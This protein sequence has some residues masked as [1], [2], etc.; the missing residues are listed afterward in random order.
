MEDLCC[1]PSPVGLPQKGCH[2]V[3]HWLLCILL[4]LR[5]LVAEG[6]LIAEQG[7]LEYIE[8]RQEFNSEALPIEFCEGLKKGIDTFTDTMQQ[9]RKRWPIRCFTKRVK[10]DRKTRI[11]SNVLWWKADGKKKFRVFFQR[12]IGQKFPSRHLVNFLLKLKKD[13]PTAHKTVFSQYVDNHQI[14]FPRTDRSYESFYEEL[15]GL[16][17]YEA[18]MKKEGVPAK[19]WIVSIAKEKEMEKSEFS[20]T[21][22]EG[23]HRFLQE[24]W[25]NMNQNFVVELKGYFNP[26]PTVSLTDVVLNIGANET[27]MKPRLIT[28]PSAQV[29]FSQADCERVEKAV[30]DGEKVNLTATWEKLTIGNRKRDHKGDARRYVSTKSYPTFVIEIRRDARTDSTTE[31]SVKSVKVGNHVDVYKEFH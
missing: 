31:I 28:C 25:Q 7:S 12:Q 24:A 1:H 27:E 29:L 14:S 2:P 26:G 23:G 17:R 30:K 11:Y 9:L 13:M 18:K 21:D 5:M 19:K 3:R 20:P 22:V 8:V 4:L 10:V 16:R 15:L 6:E